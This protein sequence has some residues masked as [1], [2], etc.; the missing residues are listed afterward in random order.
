[1]KN[2]VFAWLVLCVLLLVWFRSVDWG[3]GCDGGLCI[4]PYVGL[5]LAW[6][7]A[8]VL[9][10]AIY[11]LKASAGFRRG[12]PVFLLLVLLYWLLSGVF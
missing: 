5:V 9:V 8:G 11:G 12:L 2:Y 10:L 4:L 1:M 6:G 7:A 3:S